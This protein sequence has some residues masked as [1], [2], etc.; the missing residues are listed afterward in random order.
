[1]EH[2]AKMDSGKDAEKDKI[3][4][5]QSGLVEALQGIFGGALT[6]FAA[7]MA[8]RMMFHSS[9]VRAKR[10]KVFGAELL[11][12]FPTGFG[13]GL[14]GEGIAQYLNWDGAMRL[15]IIVF[16]AQVGPRGVQRAI[17]RWINGSGK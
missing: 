6:S 4:N 3:M 14:I 12:E 8:G 1:M 5:E 11:W 2:G 10:R 13:M 7:A 9:E 16:V 17:E 15:A